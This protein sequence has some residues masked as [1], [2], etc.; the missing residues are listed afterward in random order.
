M[1]HI[2]KTHI[3]LLMWGNFCGS[4]LKTDS[5]VRTAHTYR[6]YVYLH[7]YTICVYIDYYICLGIYVIMYIYIWVASRLYIL[8]YMDMH[9]YVSSPV[10]WAVCT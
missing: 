2:S 5:W 10:T 6:I 3:I 9:I 4:L 8:F 7:I 1:M